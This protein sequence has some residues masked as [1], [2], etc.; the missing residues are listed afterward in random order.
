MDTVRLG[1]KSDLVGYLE[2]LALP[3]ENAAASSQAAEVIIFDGGAIINILPT[4]T[5]KT[6]NAYARQQVLSYITSQL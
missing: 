3:Q 2:D 6:F 5:A 1:T 4:G